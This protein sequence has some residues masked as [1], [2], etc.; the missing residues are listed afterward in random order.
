[1]IAATVIFK[2]PMDSDWDTLRERARVRAKEAYLGLKGLRVKAFVL[3]TSTGE[4]GGMYIFETREDLD[5]FLQSDL[6]GTA[7]A[8]LGEPAVHVY[9]MP[10]YIEHGALV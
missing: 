8:K 4:F 9:E 2:V 5:A 7:A 10:A 1:M 6:I 3:N